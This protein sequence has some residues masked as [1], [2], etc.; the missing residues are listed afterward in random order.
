MSACRCHRVEGCLASLSGL[1]FGPYKPGKSP[2]AISFRT[3]RVRRVF[4]HERE[5]VAAERTPVIAVK[6]NK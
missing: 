6:C 4:W 2:L 3:A 5:V 1:D